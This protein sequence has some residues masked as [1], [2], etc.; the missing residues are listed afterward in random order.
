MR[1]LSRTLICPLFSSVC[2]SWSDGGLSIGASC[3]PV[4]GGRR[5]IKPG[6]RLRPREKRNKNGIC[7]VLRDSHHLSRSLNSTHSSK[8]V[9]ALRASLQR[10]QYSLY[11]PRVVFTDNY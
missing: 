2:P 5:E 1:L 9:S 10:V 6:G 7:P 8:M 3:Q 4:G 11:R